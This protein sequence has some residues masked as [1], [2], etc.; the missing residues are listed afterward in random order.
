MTEILFRI[1]ALVPDSP[2]FVLRCSTHGGRHLD[3][4]SG[5]VFHW[6]G[7]V[8]SDALFTTEVGLDLWGFSGGTDFGFLDLAFVD[9]PDDLL[10]LATQVDK[11]EVRIYRAIPGSAPSLIG[12]ALCRDFG[13]E[14]EA[15]IR[16]RLEAARA[17]RYD[18][19]LQSLFYEDSDGPELEGQ[20]YPIAWG[21]FGGSSDPVGAVFEDPVNLRYRVS[22]TALDVS[23][24]VAFGVLD[25][26][27]A[28]AS[29]SQFDIS[30]GGFTLNQSPDGRISLVSAGFIPG[31]AVDP[32]VFGP[33]TGFFRV[34][35]LAFTRADLWSF[36]NETDVQA[37]SDAFPVAAFPLFQSFE[38]VRLA[39]FLN[40][41]L[42]SVAGW[43]YQDPQG[44]IRLGR[45]TDPAGS[46]GT[47]EFTARDLSVPLVPPP[48]AVAAVIE[49]F[50]R[51]GDATGPSTFPTL[52]SSGGGGGAY[53]RSELSLSGVSSLSL[54]INSS[55]TSVTG[56]SSA[57]IAQAGQLG[58]TSGAAAG[59]SIAGSTGQVRRAGGSGFFPGA[60]ASGAGGGG[61]GEN[62]GG[63]NATGITDFGSGGA[64]S[65]GD[66][67][68]GAL[69][70]QSSYTDGSDVG[71][72]AGGTPGGN[73]QTR[74]GGR[75]RIRITWLIPQ[76][77]DP[78]MVGAI[79]VID[80]LAPGLSTRMRYGRR[81]GAFG[82]DEI[83]GSVSDAQR[84][85]LTT[86]WR[87]I[88]TDE[89]V[90]DFYAD[91]ASSAAPVET[92]FSGA[93]SSEAQAELDRWWSDLYPFRRRFWT[94]SMTVARA[95]EL[96]VALA[97]VVELQSD[98][99]RVLEDPRPVF[100]ARE[101][102]NYS[103]GLVT[104][105]GWG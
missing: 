37:I 46:A 79:A 85:A 16:L 17:D 86:R 87:E 96:G 56:A 38:V 1:E 83:A 58:T 70:R 88:K 61:A 29:G 97:G 22:D 54:S 26:G 9:Q 100:V 15:R 95:E 102:V 35:R 7:R 41:A 73:S 49:C 18:R 3:P 25:R 39:E 6:R 64:D 91:R 101:E 98:R 32:V 94:W 78:D 76:V 80:D 104:F 13:F 21:A 50:G 62:A 65:G 8:E 66:G 92:L 55:A 68:V 24:G 59:G 34:A 42:R 57:V 43:W 99:W 75:G 84:Q 4:V 81:S 2:A 31:S 40:Q 89:P 5:S 27:V 60:S 103:T 30:G 72:G 77:R 53:A 19:P 11:A 10:Y 45:L 71:G 105:T 36:V 67:G 33:L 82:P 47:V 12:I 28:L 69:N 51:G 23:F 74:Q 63:S 48:G 52:G 44:T 20:P 93:G 90:P 14:D